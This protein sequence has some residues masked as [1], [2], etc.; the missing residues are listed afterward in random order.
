M[1]QSKS[2]FGLRKGSTKSL[3]FS[4]LNG[5]QVT[6]D[7][8]VGGK[9]PR[10]QAQMIQRMCMAT[11][12]AG[13]AAMKQ[14]VDHSFEGYAYGADNM[15]RFISLNTKAIKADYNGE[16]NAFGYNPYGDRQLRQ[17]AYIM[18]QGSASPISNL[19]FQVNAS[20]DN[21]SVNVILPDVGESGVMSA[22]AIMEKFGVTVGDMATFVMIAAKYASPE[23]VFIF[24]RFKFLKAGT[25][26]LTGENL[27][28]YIKI[29]S[30]WA[31][32]DI[33]IDKVRL[34]VPFEGIRIENTINPNIGCIHS[35]KTTN[36][37]L[38]SNVTLSYSKDEEYPYTAAEALAT[39]PVGETYIL[40]GGTIAD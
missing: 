28:E 20:Q 38:R 40:N 1:A 32:G 16:Q 17:G 26:A 36:G 2:F 10:S 11:A 34:K 21:N 3:T 4:V 12:S 18:S 6:K 15:S 33:T 25:V 7:R 8:V 35:V 9:N 39:Y 14:I 27:Q 31:L 5:K 37:W 24:V 22:N 29:E 23:N 19:I 13:Y 30:N